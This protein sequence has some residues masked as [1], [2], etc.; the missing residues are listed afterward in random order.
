MGQESVFAQMVLPVV[1]MIFTLLGLVGEVEL[2]QFSKSAETQ[3]GEGAGQA[4]H[5][6]TATLYRS[7]KKLA[8]DVLHVL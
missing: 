1:E 5:S 8:V 7:L 4:C 6:A 3:H 2:C